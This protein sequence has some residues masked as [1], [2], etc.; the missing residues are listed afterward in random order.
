MTFSYNNSVPATNNNPSVDQPDMLTNTQSINSLVAVD[1]VSFNTASGG[2]HLQ[3][4]FS[5]KNTPLAQTDPQSVLYTASGT[6]STVAD[7]RFVNQNATFLPNAVRAWSLASAGGIVS[8]QSFN[9]TTVVRNSTG[10]Y[11]VNL[12]ANVLSGTNYGVIISCAPSGGFVVSGSYTIVNAT[13]FTLRLETTNS[14]LVDPTTF[15]FQVIQV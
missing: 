14:V 15:N 2:T 13:Q 4:T 9:V 5:S 3:T 7:L 12:P 8:S 1:H 10:L 11:T 6:A